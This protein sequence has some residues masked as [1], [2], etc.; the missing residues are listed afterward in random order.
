M[1]IATFGAGCF[2]GVEETFRKVPGVK[3]TAVG[4]MGGTTVNPTYEDVCTDKTG[5]AEVVQVEYDPAEVSYEDLLDVFWNN[6]NPT[7][8]NRQGPD[9]GTQYRSVIF[10]HTPEQ[11]ELAEAS[12]KKMDQSGKWKNP[13]VT[14]ITPAA[15]FYRA[16]EYHQRYL[17]KRGIDSCHI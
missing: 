3:N 11:K 17:Q 4:Y 5:H 12:K 2:W 15:S 14:E 16:E 7:T 13:I 8:L 9:V 6:H 10:Y 1:A